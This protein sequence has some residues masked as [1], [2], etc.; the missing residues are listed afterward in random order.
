MI[1]VEDLRKEAGRIEKLV[2]EAKKCFGGRPVFFEVLKS[3][4]SNNAK[5]FLS[6]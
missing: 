6:R 3:D 1:N 2:A 4:A 5:A